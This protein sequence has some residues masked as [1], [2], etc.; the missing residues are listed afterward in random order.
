M[1][2]HLSLPPSKRES[3][4]DLLVQIVEKRMK[5]EIKIQIFFLELSWKLIE[6]WPYFDPS[7]QKS[8]KL[9]NICYNS[10]KIQKRHIL[11]LNLTAK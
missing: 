4:F 10:R 5:N 3:H 8:Y 11:I 6:N 2:T 1:Q 9:L 7:S